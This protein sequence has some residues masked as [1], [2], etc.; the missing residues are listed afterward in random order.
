M[1]SLGFFCSPHHHFD[2]FVWSQAEAALRGEHIAPVRSSSGAADGICRPLTS[3]SVQSRVGTCTLGEA[4]SSAWTRRLFFLFS[5]FLQE[6]ILLI[7]DESQAEAHAR[8]LSHMNLREKGH[9]AVVIPLEC[10]ANVVKLN[11]GICST[12]HTLTHTYIHTRTC[13]VIS[14]CE[15]ACYL[16]SLFFFHAAVI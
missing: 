7:S 11:M 1:S 10:F 9:R 2:C 15:R 13:V 3:L 6:H 4:F 5:F 14:A 16:F 8:E 12:E